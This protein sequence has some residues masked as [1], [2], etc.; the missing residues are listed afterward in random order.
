MYGLPP[1]LQHLGPPRQ[2]LA[3]ERA[4]RW[5]HGLACDCFFQY[6]WVYASVDGERHG[7][8]SSGGGGVHKSAMLIY[9]STAYCWGNFA[10]PFVVIP[11]Q[12]PTYPSATIELLV[13]YSIKTGCHLAMLGTSIP[14]WNLEW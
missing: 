14:R 13:G 5:F 1:P 4:V 8:V 7:L 11:S 9:D 2:L 3:R 12:A 10:G 6:G